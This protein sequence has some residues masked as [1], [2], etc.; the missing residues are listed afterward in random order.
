MREAEVR[1]EQE[2]VTR[3][4]LEQEVQK[5][6]LKV[7]QEQ[8]VAQQNVAKA[9]QELEQERLQKQ[10]LERECRQENKHVREVE[11][12]LD[13]LRERAEKVAKLKLK[14]NSK[15]KPRWTSWRPS[16]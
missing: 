6:R 10:G 2:Q 11:V 1:L 15:C 5:E 14:T 16:C 4:R 12:R 13:V 7:H 8:E 3:A 9:K